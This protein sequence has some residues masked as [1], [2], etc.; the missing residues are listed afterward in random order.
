MEKES[1]SLDVHALQ[2]TEHQT[3]AASQLPK[4][5]PGNCIS[6]HCQM[7]WSDSLDFPTHLA[8]FFLLFFLLVAHLTTNPTIIE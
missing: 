3:R 1:T 8:S 7:H 4:F 5:A 2:E 6:S